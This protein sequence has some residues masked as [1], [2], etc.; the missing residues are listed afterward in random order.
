MK[1]SVDF[2]RLT[3]FI[4]SHLELPRMIS[5]L[6]SNAAKTRILAY[7]LIS[8]SSSVLAGAT[9]TIVLTPA[10]NIQ[11]A[12]NAAPANTGFILTAGTYRMQQVLPKNNDRF[13]GQGNVI[14][15]GAQ[16][17][18]FKPDPAGSGYWVGKAAPIV[19]TRGLCQTAYPLC[20]QDQDLFVDSVLQ[21]PVSSTVGLS[22]N[23]WYFD[24]STG[25]VYL[26]INP[27][28]HMIEL[29]STYYAFWGQATGVI[30]ENITVEKYATPFQS[31]A[32][33]RDGSGTGWIVENVEARWNH[34]TGVFLGTNSKLI[35]SYIHHNGETGVKF[36]G[37]NGRVLGN[38]ISWNN[39]A[40]FMTYWEAGGTK[41]WATTNLLVQDNY[42]HDNSGKG[43]WADTNNYNTQYIGNKVLN[44]IGV[45]IQHEVSY[46]AVIRFNTVKGN[47]PGPTLWVGNAQINIY[48]SPNVEAN[49]N[50]VEADASGGNGIAIINEARGSGSM[51]PW[52]AVND[53]VH[54]NNITYPGTAGASGYENDGGGDTS[55]QNRFDY[56]HYIFQG[57]SKR[58]RWQGGETWLT[59]RA[60]GQETH[61]TC[62]CK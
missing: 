50:N 59:L 23:S 36:G 1:A 18:Q 10:D 3:H 34:G 21:T 2:L 53:Y 43:L 56:N 38:E 28:G 39:Y 45:G 47:I 4:S 7:L 48:N 24:T 26:P 30:I 35:N 29:G 16:I 62:V 41:F 15:D 14:L 60:I 5:S 44:N 54:N 61:G 6:K 20:R 9:T 13:I 12:V 55:L 57:A 46:N 49:N 42:V 40:G 31:G 52:T 17:L 11:T 58:W 8:L 37:V 27:A 32:I 19:E 51:G 25:T 33:G 22:A